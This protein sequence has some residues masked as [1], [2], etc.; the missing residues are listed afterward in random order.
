MEATSKQTAIEQF[1]ERF[2]YLRDYGHRQFITK[3]V[4]CDR[5][6]AGDQWDIADKARLAASRRPYFTINTILPTVQ[7]VLGN[8]INNRV[9]TTF[10]PKGKGATESVARVLS[11]VY[12]QIAAQNRLDYLR[13][14]VFADGMTTGRGFLDVRMSFDDNLR[15]DVSVSVLDPKNVL[16]DSDAYTADPK[17]WNDVFTVRWVRYHDL[18]VMYGTR[19]AEEVINSTNALNLD[20]GS[21]T[22]EGNTFGSISA[23]QHTGYNDYKHSYNRSLLLIERQHRVPDACDH[24]LHLDT[25]ELRV[26]PQSFDDAA[27][28]NYLNNNP[29]ARVHRRLTMRIR[30]S[31]MCNGVMLHDDWSPYEHLTVIPYFPFARRGTTIGMVENLLDPQKAFNKAFS[32]MVHILNTT[33]NSGW[34]VKNGALTSMTLN[35]LEE[36][37]AETGLVVELNDMAGLE[38]IEPN[39]VPTGIDR[40]LYH[41]GE[42][43]KHISGV[44][45]YM[46]GAAREDVSAKSVQA[47]QQSGVV[48]QVKALDN[49]RQMDILLA[50][51]ILN[52]IQTFYTEQRVIR[53]VS[54]PLQGTTEEIVVNEP[55]VDSFNND[56]TIGE[57]DVTIT[58][59]PDRDLMEDTEFEQAVKLRTEANVQIPDDVIIASS[60]LREK[61]AIIQRLTQQGQS[62]EAQMAQQAQQTAIAKDA[63]DA[64][65][66]QA[67]AA[68]AMS[69]MARANGDPTLEIRLKH[70]REMRKMMADIELRKQELAMNME[71]EQRKLEQQALSDSQRSAQR[72]A[73]HQRNQAKTGKKS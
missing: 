47:N 55:G 3:A 70:E 4:T 54:D 43:I 51:C 13:S 42:A 57:Y 41:T 2:N 61:S 22:I 34:K 66:K 30:W 24:F 5:F 33:A 31:V 63:A 6:L 23:M 67:K 9:D 50:R 7:Y 25:G 19:K 65:L 71:I 14:E 60:R 27:V 45:D 59:T 49:F 32:Q 68:E 11:K 20:D 40:M 38:K 72:V 15:G 1:M 17:D 69:G 64:Q 8:Q 52:L 48:L 18:K 53:I 35:E 28:Q 58:S 73:E 12:A 36:R 37:G 26:V 16:I 21:F 62:P 29:Q 39:Q 46:L 44:S 56:L 10:M